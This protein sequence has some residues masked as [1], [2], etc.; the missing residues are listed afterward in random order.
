MEW[1]LQENLNI[2]ELKYNTSIP[3]WKPLT[4]PPAGFFLS[5][6]KWLFG[7]KDKKINGE[8]SFKWFIDVLND[9][10]LSPE[11]PGYI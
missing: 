1:E 10:S 3:V 7:R 2:T 5:N 9:I 6:T 4:L 8:T 11:A